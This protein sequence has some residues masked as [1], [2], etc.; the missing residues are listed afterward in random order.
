MTRNS[1]H[2]AGYTLLEMLVAIAILSIVM[3]AAFRLH[4]QTVSM[5]SNA[6]FYAQAPFL[7][8]SKFAEL[9]A[10]GSTAAISDAGIFGDDFPG[11]SWRLAVDDI[12]S[13]TLETSGEGLKKVDITVAFNSDEFTYLLRRYMFL[14]EK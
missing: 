8:Q 3:T 6:R 2:S 13:E 9:E 14:T 5:E 12:E 4:L 10:S 7:A 11:Y 1:R